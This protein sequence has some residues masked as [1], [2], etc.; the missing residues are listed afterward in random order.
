MNAN[1]PYKDGAWEFLKL[2]IGED[3]QAQF[4]FLPLP[5]YKKAFD[6]I[7]AEALA[8]AD[9]NNSRPYYYQKKVYGKLITIME[10][11]AADLT[12]EKIG[13]MKKELEEAKSYPI[14]VV[15]LLNIIDEEAAYYFSG[16]KSAEE[17]RSVIENRVRLY[18]G[19]N[20]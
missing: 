17:V 15:P 10:R 20:N 3:A 2:L 6:K 18:L 19:E 7:A 16:V 13:E 11:S 4:E 14:R 1:S 12:E 9:D 8:H 5:V